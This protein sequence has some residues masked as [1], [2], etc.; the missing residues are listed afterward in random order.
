LVV[1]AAVIAAALLLPLG[2][3]VAA[4][5]Y[6]DDSVWANALASLGGSARPYDFDIFLA[7]GDD[8]LAGRNPYR[9]AGTSTGQTGSPYAYPP[10][11]AMAVSPLTVLPQRLA[12]TFVPG[13]LFSLFLVAATV[14]ALLLLGIRDWRCYPVAL[15]YPVTIQAIEYGAIGPILLLLV[16]A[17]WRYRDRAGAAAVATGTAVVLKLF[18]WPCLVWLALTRRVRAAAVGAAI[19]LGLALL[20]WAAIAFRGF[21]GYPD[22]L[23]RLVD[24]EADNSYSAFAVLEAIGLPQTAARGIAIAI[25]VAILVA[26]WR[27]ARALPT[28]AVERDRR[29]LTLVLAAALV[30]TPILWLHY[31]V[32]LLVPIGLARPRLAPLWFV[33]L[34]L[35]VFEA[36]HWYGGWPRGDGRAL[37]SV[38]AV[39]AVVF[40]VSLWP[41]RAREGGEQ[42]APARA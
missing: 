7:A 41:R 38:T 14:G 10:V 26:A 6:H 3:R 19:A 35:S 37:G 13:V 34:V 8:V 32:L 36:L 17:A 30:L 24:A 16:A 29:S 42:V 40:V 25:G 9:H 22:L 39:V 23:R 5:S 18:L 11:L 15:L 21:E 20:S 1:V 31:L 33:P 12:R 28:D 4:R 27:V 2:A